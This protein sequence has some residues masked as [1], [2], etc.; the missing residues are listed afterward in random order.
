MI[1]LY[2]LVSLFIAWIWIDYFRMIDVF[3]KEHWKQ[4]LPMF[5]LGTLSIPI[6]ILITQHFVAPFHIYMNGRPLNDLVYF[7][8]GV[9][10]VEEFAKMVPFLLFAFFFRKKIN[11]PLDYIIYMCIS[12]LAFAAIENTQYFNRLGAHIIDGRSILSTVTH[13]YCSAIVA[14]GFILY[15]KKK[16]GARIFIPIVFLLIAAINHG[17]F[18]T[19]ASSG[20]PHPWQWIALALY[21]LVNI[22]VFSDIMNNAL[23]N[24]PHFTYKK[25]I[26]SHKVALRLMLYY[27]VVFILQFQLLTFEIGYRNAMLN[28]SA[29]TVLIGFIVTI[30]SVRLGRFTL[31]KGFWKPVIPELPFTFGTG[32]NALALGIKGSYHNEITLN[33]YYDEYCMV[34]PVSERNSTLAYTRI[35][36]VEEKFYAHQSI[37]YFVLRVYE[38]ESK[39]AFLKYIIKAKVKGN[40]RVAEKYPIVYLYEATENPAADAQAGKLQFVEWVYLIPVS[41]EQN[42]I[43]NAEV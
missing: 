40:D 3:E 5:L 19:V 29:T 18:N 9:G 10:L 41:E 36:F 28:L 22:S 43:D 33:Q 6:T 26:D 1:V 14:Y 15:K 7:I 8:L 2:A 31:V 11:E 27:G 34:N 23:N 4:L 16:H 17:L 42:S 21:F 38:D 37:P 39:T 13:V 24:S 25:V 32:N 30:T 35:G 20:L 12:A